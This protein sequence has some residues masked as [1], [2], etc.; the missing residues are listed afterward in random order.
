MVLFHP[1]SFPPTDFRANER[2]F[3]IQTRVT[4]GALSICLEK[5]VVP[6]GNQMERA[7]SCFPFHSFPLCPDRP[8]SDT[9]NNLERVGLEEVH[10]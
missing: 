5:P 10:G 6:V 9:I 3:E 8:T 4:Q 2:L 1:Y 7:L